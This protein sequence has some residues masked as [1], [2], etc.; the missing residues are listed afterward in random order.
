MQQLI[1][2]IGSRKDRGKDRNSKIKAE[3]NIIQKQ[4]EQQQEVTEIP[5]YNSRETKSYIGQS[6]A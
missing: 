1:I 3:D 5:L 2:Q 6:R 4:A